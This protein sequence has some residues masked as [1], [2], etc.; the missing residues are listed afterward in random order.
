MDSNVWNSVVCD[1]CKRKAKQ[2]RECQKCAVQIC[3]KCATDTCPI[4]ERG[5]LIE[6]PIVS[7]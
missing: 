4:C 6:R 5:T 3:Y 7:P 1:N 2:H